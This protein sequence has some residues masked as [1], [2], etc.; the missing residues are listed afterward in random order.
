M[1]QTLHEIQRGYILRYLS[2]SFP[3]A[4]TPLSLLYE[5]R[6]ARYASTSQNLNW[7]LHYLEEKG[8]IT[9]ERK[10]IEIGEEEEI[11]SAKITVAGIDLVD[12]RRKGEE[13]RF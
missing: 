4:A 7:Q 10:E 3:Q 2:L 1:D 11:L 8:W 5:L 6:R 13:V 9:L 12:R